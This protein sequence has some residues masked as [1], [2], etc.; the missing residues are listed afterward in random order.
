[1]TIMSDSEQFSTTVGDDQDIN[2]ITDI[3]SDHN[4]S[5]NSS[6]NT[7]NGIVG[8]PRDE[9]WEYFTRTNNE[10]S[11]EVADLSTTRPNKKLKSNHT[12]PLT[13]YYNL[14]KIDENKTNKLI[15]LLFV[16]D[17]DLAIF[18]S[19]N[20][21]RALL[22]SQQFWIDI[23]QL[24]AILS[25]AKCSVKNVEFTSTTMADI[26][27]ELIKLAI[28]IKEIPRLNNCSLR[29]KCFKIFNK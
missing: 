9:V 3:Y 7:D 29:E 24:R 8:C 6:S 5:P 10:S 25:L 11:Q 18:N 21:V 27:V 26:F 15:N 14:D 19:A 1:D 23:E 4:E 17:K 20:E 2:N 28:A 13:A 16:L 22:R 12:I